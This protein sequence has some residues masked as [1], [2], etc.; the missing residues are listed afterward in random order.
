[1]YLAC[2]KRSHTLTPCK[3]PYAYSASPIQHTSLYYPPVVKP[4]FTHVGSSNHLPKQQSPCKRHHCKL[5]N[6]HIVM[7]ATALHQRHNTL[8]HI[9]SSSALRSLQQMK[10]NELTINN[11]NIHHLVSVWLRFKSFSF[12]CTWFCAMYIIMVVTYLRL[13]LFLAS[14]FCYNATKRTQFTKKHCSLIQLPYL[15]HFETLC[16]T[17]FKCC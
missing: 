5:L 3:F 2:R 11:L 1:M 8:G 16:L 10:D 7:P 17:Q 14:V 12:T 9:P 6:Q 13:L 15:L 4:L